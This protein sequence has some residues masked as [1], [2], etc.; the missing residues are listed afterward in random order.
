MFVL[1]EIYLTMFV[2]VEIYLTMFVLVEIYLI[3]FV[4]V[5]IYLTI[6]LGQ[7]PQILKILKNYCYLLQ[8]K[9]KLNN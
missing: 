5:E 1:V 9:K 6:T 4:L 7:D 2:L 3:M 8:T